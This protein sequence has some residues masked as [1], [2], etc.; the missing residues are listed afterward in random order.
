MKTVFLVVAHA[1]MYPTPSSKWGQRHAW[2]RQKSTVTWGNKHIWSPPLRIADIHMCVYVPVSGLDLPLSPTLIDADTWEGPVYDSPQPV[3]IKSCSVMACEHQHHLLTSRLTARSPHRP[4][5][6]SLQP[7]I[8]VKSYSR[9]QGVPNKNIHMC[10][11]ATAG[12]ALPPA[13][14]V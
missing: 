9:S 12:N 11:F 4:S 10:E 6:D 1:Y 14:G 5:T 8:A 3:H 2:P 7:K 13:W